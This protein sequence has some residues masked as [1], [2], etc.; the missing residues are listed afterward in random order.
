[1]LITKANG[2]ESFGCCHASVELATITNV[3][4]LIEQAPKAATWCPMLSANFSAANM[5]PHPTYISS[6]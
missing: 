4:E 5:P 3:Y 6:Q 1:M 2:M